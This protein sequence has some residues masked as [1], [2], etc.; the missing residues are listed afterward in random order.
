MAE[1]VA[2]GILGVMVENTARRLDAVG[3]SSRATYWGVVVLCVTLSVW[4]VLMAVSMLVRPGQPGA[5]GPWASTGAIIG[6]LAWLVVTATFHRN[7][8]HVPVPD[9]RKVTVEPVGGLPSVVISWRTTFHRQPVFVAVVVVTAAAFVALALHQIDQL[10][11]W[12]PLVV[13]A[14]LLLALPDRTIELVRPLRVVLNPLGVGVTGLGG[15]A[16]LDWDDIRRVEIEHE[17]QWAVV[18]LAGSRA[19]ESWHF[20]RRA[21][22]LHAPA[23]ER[24]Q[25]DVPGPAFPVDV[26]TV[27]DALEHYCR[28]PAARAEL[29]GEAGRRRLLGEA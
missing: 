18:R 1:G 19:P 2:S 22:F 11:W 27:I 5:W 21:R 25:L 23:P 24:P 17:S 15:D 20:A 7:Y 9:S 12:L 14:P 3:A 29:A 16:W 28:T 13:V 8:L 10:L 26:Q 6:G 4:L